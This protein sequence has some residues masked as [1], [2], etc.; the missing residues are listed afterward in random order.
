MTAAGGDGRGGAGSVSGGAGAGNGASG[1]RIHV[2]R[3]APAK[4]NLTLAVVGRRDDGYHALHSVMVPLSLGDA[5]TVSA[6]SPGATRDSLRVTGLPLPPTKDNLVLRA[7]IAT[8]A[9]VATAPH[10]APGPGPAAPRRP[11]Q[12]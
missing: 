3:F 5:L 9:A 4:L 10:P 8:R 6:T 12:R 1:A 11:A 7:I 2:V